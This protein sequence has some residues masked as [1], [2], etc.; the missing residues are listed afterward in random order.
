LLAREILDQ[1]IFE[2][3]K[4]ASISM[5]TNKQC[6][7]E[8]RLPRASIRFQTSSWRTCNQHSSEIGGARCPLVETE[9]S[10][11]LSGRYPNKIVPGLWCG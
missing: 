8:K 2:T 10:R 5:C 9:L 7:M 11:L 4:K 6:D 1:I 3:K